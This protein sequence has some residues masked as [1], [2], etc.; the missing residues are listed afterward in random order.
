MVVIGMEDGVRKAL[1]IN[2]DLSKRIAALEIVVAALMQS[3][4]EDV[5]RKVRDRAA[6]LMAAA[7][8]RHGVVA[9]EIQTR[10]EDLLIGKILK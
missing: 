7:V 9:E 2:V 3:E 8:G 10:T 5:R 4:L 1:E 6:A